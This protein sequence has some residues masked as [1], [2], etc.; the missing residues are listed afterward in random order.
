MAFRLYIVPVIGDGSKANARRPKYFAD[1]TISASWSGMDYGFEPWMVVGADLSP[2][3]DAFVIGQPD[4]MALPLDLDTQMSAQGVTTVQTKL[5][6]INIPAD[7]V[8]TAWTWRAMTREVLAMCSILQRFNGVHGNTRMFGGAVTLDS[9]IGSLSVAVR[10]D[11]ITTA[12]SLGLDTGGIT[13]PT[14]IRTAW[15]ALADQMQGQPFFI[16]VAI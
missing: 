2:A 7:W 15:K 10:N 8:T 5:E 6:A 12:T 1:G 14:L 9:T 16:G 11:L 13:G 4:G 3:D